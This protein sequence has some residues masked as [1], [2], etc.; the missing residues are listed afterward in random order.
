M[1]HLLFDDQL[2]QEF[3]REVLQ[4]MRRGS[5]PSAGMMWSVLSGC[6]SMKLFA[7]QNTI[8]LPSGENRGK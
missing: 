1:S 3:I 7:L 6:R 5:P 2:C 8:H 4:R